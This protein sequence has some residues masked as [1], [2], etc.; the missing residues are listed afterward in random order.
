[1][2]SEKNRTIEEKN[3]DIV[4]SINY[5]KRI[6]QAI[7]PEASNIATLLPESFIYY[8][9]KDIV[10]GDFYWIAE[11]EGRTIA[12]VADSTGHGVPGA[13]MSMLGSAFL[14][15]IVLEKGVTEPALILN[16]L[17]DKIIRALKQGD[18]S[19]SRDGIDMTI[20][21]IQKKEA[22][23][24]LQFAGANNPL[25]I[26]RQTGLT[27]IKGD[28]QP[29]GVRTGSQVPF[30]NH[31]LELEAGDL[32]YLFSD[33]FADQFGGENGKKFRYK[34]LQKLISDMSMESLL[35]QKNILSQTLLQWKGNLEQV[36]DI[37]VM[38]I[39]LKA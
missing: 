28:K 38:G 5:A 9:P 18:S 25:W 16:H 11:R 26:F 31:R 37:L 10:S 15:E 12:V 14:N 30:T 33:G 1:M 21:S 20:I 8:Q 29:V 35:E 39:R 2:L 27:E 22:K 32:I 7:L 6:Q 4:D 17:R 34:P 13:F 36:D 3:K 19:E 24:D 23:F